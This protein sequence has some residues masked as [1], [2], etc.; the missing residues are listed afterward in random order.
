[1]SF[2]PASTGHDARAA[3]APTSLEARA[4]VTLSELAGDSELVA[5]HVRDWWL[6][7]LTSHESHLLTLLDFTE[8]WGPAS[9]GSSVAD[10]GSFPGHYAALLSRFGYEVAAID[11]DPDRAPGLWT[12][13]GIEAWKR[14][15][16]VED[17]PFQSSSVDFATLSEVLEHLR[18]N[19]FKPLREIHRVLRPGGR[20]LVSV[21]YVSARHRIR[22]LLGKDYQGDVIAEYRSLEE[23]GHMGHYRLLS[24]AEVHAILTHSGFTVRYETVAG[25]LPGGRWS[26]IQHLGP[27]CDR[28][29]SHFYVVAEK[30]T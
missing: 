9:R 8:K 27:L 16:E 23:V 26:F 13:Y 1:M 19:P 30:A 25:W 7:Y 3:A 22:F 10:V 14:D 17:L 5:P 2:A 18:V 6:S 4:R 21:P 29:R 15:I 28:F 12:K 24:R 11:L 20:L